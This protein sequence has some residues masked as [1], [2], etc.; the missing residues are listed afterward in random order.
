MIEYL[1]RIPFAALLRR[2]ITRHLRNPP[3]LGGLVDSIEPYRTAHGLP[4]CRML[5]KLFM[6]FTFFSL[7]VGIIANRST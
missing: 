4:D 2:A 1:P 6:A 5:T 3:D 7:C